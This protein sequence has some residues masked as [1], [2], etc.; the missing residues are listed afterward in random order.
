MLSALALLLSLTAIYSV[1]A[2]SVSGRTREIGVRV[3]LGAGRSQVVRVILRRPLSQIGI[4]IAAGAVLVALAFVGLFEST[5]TMTESVVIAAYAL[6]MMGVCQLA[7][8]VPVR[9]ALRVDPA[10][11]LRADS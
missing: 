1:I 2:F 8:V 11:V 9:R 10:V 4:G 7:C 6:I 3:A 5:P